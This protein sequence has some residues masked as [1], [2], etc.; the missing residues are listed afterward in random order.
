MA[1]WQWFTKVHRKVFNLT[2]GRLGASMGGQSIVMIE[3]IGRKSGQLRQVP[4]VCYPYKD[5]V[6]VVASNNGQHK[7]P[8]WWLNLQAQPQVNAQLGKQRFAVSAHEL[9]GAEREAAWQVIREKNPRQQ[10]YAD[11]TERELP[12]VYLQPR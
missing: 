4:V 7:H 3:T 8:L 9:Q 6:T 5:F 1:N 11:N 12:V 2:G 10:V